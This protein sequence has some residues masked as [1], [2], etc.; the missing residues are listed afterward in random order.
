LCIEA[1]RI[2]F[3]AAHKIN[4]PVSQSLSHVGYLVI[5]EPN[6]SVPSLHLNKGLVKFGS[7]EAIMA[8]FSMTV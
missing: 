8:V 2:L 3:I 6:W 1:W 7:V 5:T 4:T